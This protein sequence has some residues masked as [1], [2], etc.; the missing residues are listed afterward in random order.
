MLVHDAIIE[1]VICG[2][3]SI[4]VKTLHT[5]MK[6]LEQNIGKSNKTG[7]ENQFTVCVFAYIH[8]VV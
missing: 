6:T 7:Y 5:Q 1:K 8:V 3:N 2:D 4:H